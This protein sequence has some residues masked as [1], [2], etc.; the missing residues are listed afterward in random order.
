MILKAFLGDSLIYGLGTVLTRGLA[1]IL[2]PLYARLLG[3]QGYGV[4]EYLNLVGS[5]AWLIAALEVSIGM[6]RRV[7]DQADTSL[8]QR[9]GITAFWFTATGYSVVALVLLA[10]AEPLAPL[11]LGSADGAGLLRVT[12][13]SWWLGGLTY[14]LQNQLRWELRA[15]AA[16]TLA[17]VVALVNIA[18]ALL[19]V[20]WLGL[21]VG[22]ALAA[23]GA[24]GLAGVAVGL[25]LERPFW[26]P[27]ID[28]AAL[29]DMLRF[30]VPLLPSSLATLG[31]QYIDRLM[32]K[33][34][35]S[36]QDLGQLAMAYRLAAPVS[37][38]VMV[39]QTALMPLV[40]KHHAEAGVREDLARL[41][42]YFIVLALL[43][44]ALLSLLADEL[45][46]LLAG[47]A[48]SSAAGAV[49]LLVLSA[50]LSGA[51]TFFPGL[52]IGKRTATISV[53]AMAA[54][55]VN[56]LVTLAAAPRMGMQGAALG[57][58]AG[59]AVSLAST[60]ILS[61]RFYAVPL[62]LRS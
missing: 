5:I 44:V 49:P 18:A 9:Y 33:E 40:F 3:P 11:L 47:G 6:A 36:F 10:V 15:K 62:R 19:F 7:S 39:F 13:A 21:G 14:A 8:R 42:R 2:L 12:A 52:W 46:A 51:A 57:S 4:L 55:V 45:V 30:S 41:F 35:L 56:A 48:F 32:V 58:C 28:G 34:L 27:A 43:I 23:S 61:R 37:L 22:G 24:G 20:G 29:R 1:L 59:A 54:L 38:C 26:R 25:A 53:I 60:F 16:A 50:L 31:A 17:V